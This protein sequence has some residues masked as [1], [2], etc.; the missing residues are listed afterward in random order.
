MAFFIYN[1]YQI[2]VSIPKDNS[3]YHTF[4]ASFSTHHTS[5][6]ITQD[7]EKVYFCD[8]D[9]FLFAWGG[10][11]SERRQWLKQ[12]GY[13]GNELSK[14]SNDINTFFNS[15]SQE[16]QSYITEKGWI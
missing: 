8:E 9:L 14:N 5:V 15:I 7:N 3:C 6:P 4:D 2:A 10:G 1:D 12:N 13:Q 11:K 16:Q